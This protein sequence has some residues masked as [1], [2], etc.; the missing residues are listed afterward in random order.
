MK[1]VLT[2]F[3]IFC[4]SFVYGQTDKISMIDYVQIINNHKDEALFYY[5]NNWEQLRIKAI[6]EDYIDSYQ[7]LE[8]E[9]TETEPYNFILITTFKNEIQYHAREEHFNRLIEAGNG[10]KLLNDKKPGE[11]RKVIKHIENVKHWN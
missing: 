8:T 4:V 5:Q 6:E 2:L 10:L 9:P 7:L 1:T 3:F 11:F